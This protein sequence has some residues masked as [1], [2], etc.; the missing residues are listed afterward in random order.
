METRHPIEG[1][2]GSEFPANCNHCG[3]MAAWNHMALKFVEEFLRV[4]E[5][6]TPYSEIF[7]ILLSPHWSTLLCSNFVKF[8][9]REIDQIDRCLLDKKQIS[10]H[11]QT[12]ATVWIVPKICQG[13]PPTMYSEC[14]RFYPNWFTFGGVIAECLNTAK[15]HPK[16]N[17][18]FGG[19]QASSWI[20]RWQVCVHVCVTRW[21][22][23][24]ASLLVSTCQRVTL[25]LLYSGT[26][27][28]QRWCRLLWQLWRN[29]LL[30]KASTLTSKWSVL[31]SALLAL[32]CVT[33]M[34]VCMCICMS[35]CVYT[36]MY[37]YTHAL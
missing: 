29:K 30:I 4:F 2:F 5:K 11:S 34:S 14:S 21:M 15:S 28:L 26:W 37:A 22:C 9:R 24:E 3:V 1:S 35:V 8:G 32:I 6:P 16:V 10:P 31:Q 27:M 33:C 36:C 23:L 25:T 19:S 7:K 18:V 20:K 12:V 13:Q 17:P